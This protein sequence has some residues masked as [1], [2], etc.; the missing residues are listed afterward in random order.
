MSSDTVLLNAQIMYAQY[1]YDAAIQY[2]KSQP[3]FA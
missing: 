1:N 2:L 3:D